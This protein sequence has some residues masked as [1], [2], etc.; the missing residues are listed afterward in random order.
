M[1]TP[2]TTTPPTPAQ[3]I[4][5]S[6]SAYEAFLATANAE[7][8][9]PRAAA[10]NTQALNSLGDALSK[11][12]ADRVATPV[13]P[14]QSTATPLS[15]PVEA[16][17]PS[18]P[19][20]SRSPDGR[21]ASR[22]DQSAPSTSPTPSPQAAATPAIPS[23]SAV[24]GPPVASQAAPSAAATSQ[25]SPPSPATP[26]AD[27]FQDLPAAD[28]FD[29]NPQFKLLTQ[30]WKR[31]HE[32]ADTFRSQ[33]E[34]LARE[35]E[36][37]R[38]QQ[39]TAKPTTDSTP[40]PDLLTLQHE[41]DDLQARLEAIA[42][43]RSPRFESMFKPR[44]EAAIAQAKAAVGPAQADRV[45]SLLSLPE[46]SYRDEQ[47]ESILN[48]IGPST[49]RAQK[50]SSAVADIDRLAAERQTYANQSSQLFKSWQ[51][52]E[53]ANSQRQQAERIKTIT[54]T[55]NSTVD[56][57]KR[58]GADLDAPSIE[59]ARDVFMGKRDVREVATA[60]MWVA[61]GPRAAATAL[62]LQQENA[63]LQAEVSRLRG[64]QPGTASDAATTIQTEPD[65]SQKQGLEGLI[66]T[67]VRNTSIGR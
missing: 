37:L 38:Q 57:W 33:A 6:K 12:G 43:E 55:F 65:V 49:M 66:E 31:L 26:A 13:A 67:I 7:V 59:L 10:H 47:L 17:K 3:T 28:V 1:A 50:L 56:E 40:S 27:P 18:A 19:S 54:D 48:E 39:S 16:P 2:A 24:P 58:S 9:Q 11:A 62:K 44:Q 15:A 29:K 52:E 8:F 30:N 32:K 64:V 25:V 23:T 36:T 41:R 21:F 46:S 42:V 63:A 22:A 45:A 34:T 51:A 60:A 53:I 5:E 14:T 4:A 20:T 61:Y 35:V